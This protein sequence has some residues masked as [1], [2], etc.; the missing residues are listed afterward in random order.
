MHCDFRSIIFAE[1]DFLVDLVATMK[2]GGAVEFLLHA[3]S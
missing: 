3:Y 1:V 2:A